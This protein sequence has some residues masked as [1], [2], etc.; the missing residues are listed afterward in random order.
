MA[1]EADDCITEVSDAC[2]FFT[3]KRYAVNEIF[4]RIIIRTFLINGI[5]TIVFEDFCPQHCGSDPEALG[6]EAKVRRPILSEVLGELR[7][8]ALAVLIPGE[9]KKLFDVLTRARIHVESDFFFLAI[10]CLHVQRDLECFRNL[11]NFI[12]VHW[13]S[14]LANKNVPGK[15]SE[16]IVRERLMEI[17][18]DRCRKTRS[19]L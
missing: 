14:I 5:H 2:D 13:H 16:G 8:T 17:S 18:H 11:R 19:L 15:P 7:I 6:K 10:L 12:R 3:Q 1:E 4:I 9:R